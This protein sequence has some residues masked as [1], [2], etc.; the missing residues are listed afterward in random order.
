MPLI[1]H[2]A[3]VPIPAQQMYE[4][5]NCIEAY[6]EFLPYCK[7]AKIKEQ[8]DNVVIASLEIVKDPIR[9]SFTTR[10]T[11]TP[12]DSIMIELLD[13]PFEYLRGHWQFIAL[14]DN[15]CKVNFT[16]DFAFKNKLFSAVS[17]PLLNYI[18]N[19]MVKAF[20]KRAGSTTNKINQQG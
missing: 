3:L 5:V 15:A 6:P 11:L 8:K 14:E 19:D 17:K 18:A 13:G 20:I 2:T 9:K 1:Q 4:L 10:N 7:S 12:P 16:L